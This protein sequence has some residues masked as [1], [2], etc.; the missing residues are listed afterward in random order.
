MNPLGDELVV[1]TRRACLESEVGAQHLQ[2]QRCYLRHDGGGAA[3]PPAA[4][5]MQVAEPAGQHRGLVLVSAAQDRGQELHARV[6]VAETAQR[7]K[8]GRPYTVAA[9][10]EGRVDAA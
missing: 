7:L 9:K 1:H 6:A 2:A 3:V 4:P 5:E 10:A 8:L